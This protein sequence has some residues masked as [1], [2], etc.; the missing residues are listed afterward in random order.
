MDGKRG[1]T[2]EHD[3]DLTSHDNKL[4]SDEPVVFEH[5]LENIEPVVETSCVPLVENLHPDERVENG[6]LKSLSLVGRLVTKNTRACE[7]ENERDRELINGLSDD[8]LPHRHSDQG[9]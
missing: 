6:A 7:I 3:E 9:S 8:H 5:A 1:T 4:D 2:N